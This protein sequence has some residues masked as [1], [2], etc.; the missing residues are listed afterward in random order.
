MIILGEN[1]YKISSSTKPFWSSEE[2][3]QQLLE[4]LAYLL[5]PIYGDKSW[6][7]HISHIAEGL[8]TLPSQDWT[9]TVALQEQAQEQSIPQTV[10]IL[11]QLCFA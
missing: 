8:N 2:F 6:T 5:L 9:I 7:L 3:V 1:M 4:I 11:N 10:R